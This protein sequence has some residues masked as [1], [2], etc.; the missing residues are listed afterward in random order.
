MLGGQVG[1]ADNVEIG[2]GA[3][4][5]AQAGVIGNID[6]G[7]QVLGMPAID[8]REAM[9]IAGFTMRLPKMAEQLRRLAARVERLEAAEDNQE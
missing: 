7:K 9:R 1:V 5:G 8:R 6:A 3:M 4:V 2:D